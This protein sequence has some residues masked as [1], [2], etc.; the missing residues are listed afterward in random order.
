MKIF[1]NARLRNMT[2][3]LT[4]SLRT[5]MIIPQPRMNISMMRPHVPTHTLKATPAPA[6]VPASIDTASMKM[7][8]LCAR[9]HQLLIRQFFLSCKGRGCAC[10]DRI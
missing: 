1:T 7:H 4:A 8:H 10:V 2:S 9:V 3:I 5:F 6:P